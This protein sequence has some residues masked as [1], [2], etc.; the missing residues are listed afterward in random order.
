MKKISILAFFLLLAVLL[1]SCKDKTKEEWSHFYGYTNNDI[2]GEYS[3]S[4]INKVF[5]DLEPSSYCHICDDAEISITA[6]SATMV[7]FNINCPNDNYSRTFTG[8]PT[9]NPNDCMIRMS[10]GYT[11]TG[12]GKLRAYNV[13]ASV[14]RNDALQIRLSGF[15]A[16]N[17][18]K[19]V[20]VPN[21]D[22]ILYDTI[23][24]SGVNYYFDVIKN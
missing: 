14:Y 19:L 15:A 20:A 5:D 23:Q 1:V 9:K 24:D 11:Q 22:P 17:T 2:I 12:G 18:Y 8:V 21:T 10:S 6:A 4:N 3:F 7:N 13:Q 16:M